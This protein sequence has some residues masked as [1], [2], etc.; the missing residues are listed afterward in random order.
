MSDLYFSTLRLYSTFANK[1]IN[2]KCYSHEESTFL[3]IVAIL[4]PLVTFAGKTNPKPPCMSTKMALC[5]G[6]TPGKRPLFFGV[7]YTFPFAHA[8]RVMG[9]LSIDHKEAI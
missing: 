4:L 3:L 6:R 1:Q 5:A 7:N 8:Y 2:L 9:L